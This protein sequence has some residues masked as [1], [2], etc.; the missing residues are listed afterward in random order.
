MRI[1]QIRKEGEGGRT[2]GVVVLVLDVDV[3]LLRLFVGVL[4]SVILHVRI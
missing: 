3:L 1:T 2:F 4:E